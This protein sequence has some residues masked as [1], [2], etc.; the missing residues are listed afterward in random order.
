MYLV[1]FMG[2]PARYNHT[3]SNLVSLSL[4]HTIASSQYSRL[5]GLSFSSKIPTQ[6]IL[7]PDICLGHFMRVVYH[8]ICKRSILC[9]KI[10]I[11]ADGRK[12]KIYWQRGTPR[13]APTEQILQATRQDP[14]SPRD[15]SR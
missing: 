9:Q 11:R 2:K 15:R 7:K 8:L 6:D 1:G 5:F 4:V 10:N 12:V 13:K 3:T 14:W